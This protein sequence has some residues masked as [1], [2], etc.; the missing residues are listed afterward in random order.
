[1]VNNININNNNNNNNIK[2]INTNINSI[3]YFHYYFLRSITFFDLF[4]NF[5]TLFKQFFKEENKMLIKLALNFI[6]LVSVQF[7]YSYSH[8][9]LVPSFRPNG[10]RRFTNGTNF[11]SLLLIENSLYVGAK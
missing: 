3:F 1:M 2:N 5:F 6:W 11:T 7:V 8:E 10:L 4:I 9:K